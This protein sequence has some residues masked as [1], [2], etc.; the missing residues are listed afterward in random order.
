M[1]RTI[2]QIY[3]S[4]VAEKQSNASLSALQPN[5]DSAQT[6]LTNLTSSSKV[7]IWRLIF[8]VVA[9]AHSL[10]EQMWD[11]TKKEI[12][13]LAASLVPGTAAWYAEQAKKF[14]FGDQLLYINGVFQYATINPSARIVTNAACVES[15]GAVLIKIAK[16]VSA[17]P[18][19]LNASELAAF[20]AYLAQIKYAGVAAS[21]VSLPADN[22]KLFITVYYDP[23]L[24]TASGQL[25]NSGIFPV[26]E[27]VQTYINKLPFNGRF[28]LSE[29]TDLLQQAQ[30]VKDVV[31]NTAYGRYGS[32]PFVQFTVS[33]NTQ[34]GYVV[35]DP[36]TPLSASVTYVP[37]V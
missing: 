6:L 5:I 22:I 34:A 31:I 17:T 24:L 4:M 23:Q 8:W 9:F 1:A 27:A 15:S 13:T 35:I 37:Y 33:Y 36:A 3:D 14:Q 2:K 26:N 16:T 21:A 10:L 7:A 30:G 19:P 12:E 18:A 32:S 20:N 11:A 29:Q 25:I 28:T